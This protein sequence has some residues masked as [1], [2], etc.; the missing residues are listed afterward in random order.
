MALNRAQR[1][2][3]RNTVVK[4]RRTLEEATSG[5][6][7][8][9]F[10]IQRSGEIEDFSNMGH[11]SAEEF[12][13]REQVASHLFHMRAM[14]VAAKDAV[15]RLV[16]EVSYTHLNR[17]CAYK[18]LETQGSLRRVVGRGLGSDEVVGRG[19]K[20]NAFMFYLADYPDD[21]RLW[22]TGKQDV[23]YRHFL[24]WLGDA[25]ADE[26]GVLF[27]SSDPANQLFPPHR[28]LENVLES[29]NAEDLEEVWN[30]DETIG[31]VY[32]YYTPKELREQ[33]RKESQT[34][35]NSYE[36]SFRNQF[37]TPDYVVRFL[38]DNTLGRTWYEMRQGNTRLNNDANTWYAAS[39]PCS[40]PRARKSPSPFSLLIGTK[41]PLEA[42]EPRICGPGPILT[43]GTWKTSSGTPCESMATNTRNASSASTAA[44]WPTSG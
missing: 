4:C 35:R 27:S 22:S 42:A 6:L 33:A 36:L 14:G 43:F 13:Y 11:L 41:G 19:T 38:V 37:Y 44:A 16:R 17:L 23:A 40:W 8:G 32:Q 31:W 1:N 20:S 39:T 9:R 2:D 34:P 12:E 7:E 29:L 18:L 26:V 15:D 24:E 21:E 28:I 3:L 10:G 30:E 25:L 5:I